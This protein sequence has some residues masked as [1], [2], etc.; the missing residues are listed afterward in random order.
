MSRIP[1]GVEVVAVTKYVGIPET[2]E[3]INAGAQNIGESRI[4]SARE[5]LSALT[6]PINWHMIGPLQKN[7]AKYAVKMFKLIQSVDSTD[8]AIELD[9]QARKSEKVQDILIQINIGQEPQKHGFLPE[10]ILEAAREISLLS[11]LRVRGLMTI[12][13]FNEDPEAS[14]PYFREMKRIF[15]EVQL[16]ADSSLFTV[17]SMGMSAD[18][19][20]AIDEGASMIRV[21][22][23]LF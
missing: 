11:N 10:E 19:Q 1:A 17:L 23:L 4:Q 20:I 22:S 3:L 21:G 7:K 18:H 2:L 13:P 9:K 12:P 14:R 6:Q 15:D 8:L 5:K 16:T